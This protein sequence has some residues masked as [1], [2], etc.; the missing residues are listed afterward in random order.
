MKA[1]YMVF[2]GKHKKAFILYKVIL[3][4]T[5]FALALT[6]L[7]VEKIELPNVGSK[8]RVSLGF[9]VVL[10]I[11]ISAF[12]KAFSMP[13]MPWLIF[14]SIFILS[15]CFRMIIDTVIMA[16]GLLS[17]PLFIDY[18]IFRPVFNNIYYQHYEG[19]H[20]KQV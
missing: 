7:F 13:K 17:I 6:T 8:L 1:N 12:T 18:T 2:K 16:T 10:L 9:V 3:C 14:F 20:E 11:T 19:Y 5:I 4:F 15:V